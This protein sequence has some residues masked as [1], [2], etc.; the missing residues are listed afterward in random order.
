MTAFNQVIENFA[1]SVMVYVFVRGWDSNRAAKAQPSPCTHTG[2]PLFLPDAIAPSPWHSICCCLLLNFYH[3]IIFSPIYLS[4]MDPL[5]FNF[6]IDPFHLHSLFPFPPNALISPLYVPKM[7]RNSTTHSPPWQQQ[8]RTP[9]LQMIMLPFEQNTRAFQHPQRTDHHS[10]THHKC[11]L[12]TCWS[13]SR[14]L[15]WM[16]LP[17]VNTWDIIPPI[18]SHFWHVNYWPVW[19]LMLWWVNNTKRTSRAIS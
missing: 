17:A 1:D 4:Q 10:W 6:C 2:C 7:W 14:A 13:G 5:L 12:T 11:S 16:S 19:F 18:N 15:V 9:V 8:N 3:L